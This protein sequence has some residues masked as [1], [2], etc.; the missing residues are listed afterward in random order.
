MGNL[1]MT[2]QSKANIKAAVSAHL[3]RDPNGGYRVVLQGTSGEGHIENAA[4]PIAYKSM[5][6]AKKAAAAHN[7]NI[8][9]ELKP[10]I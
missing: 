3:V 5:A 9:P 10:T 8:K 4:G 6:A 7:T 2:A 1:R